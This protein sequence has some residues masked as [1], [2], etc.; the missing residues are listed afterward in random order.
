LNPWDI[1]AG[2]IVVREAGGIVTDWH[3]DP[4]AVLEG[5]DVLAGSPAWH[6]CML[7]L[8]GETP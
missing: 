6:E 5:G 3:G 1:A 4:L 8:M 2:I 7:G